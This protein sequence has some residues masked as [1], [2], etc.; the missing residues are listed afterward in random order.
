MGKTLKLRDNQYPFDGVKEVR[1]I[2]RGL[3]E[4]E[5]GCFAIHKLH[6][7]DIFGDYAYYETPGGGIDP[8][9]DEI[10]ALKRE[11]YE[12]IGYKLKDIK[13]IGD[14]EDYYNLIKRE[15]HNHYFYAKCDGSYLGKYFKSAGDNFII[16]T[17]YLPIEEIISLYESSPK[18]KI[19]L[20]CYN[21]E[22]PMWELLLKMRK[23]GLI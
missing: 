2:S 19:P 13:K 7:N 11:C 12:E 20:L 4:D 6:R 10:T 8:G 21:R 1:E 5:N 23:E 14:V 9:E 17:L 22:V 15:N 3:I 18:E 16:E